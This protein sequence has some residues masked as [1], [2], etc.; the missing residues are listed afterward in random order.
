MGKILN[1]VDTASFLYMCEELFVRKNY[2]FE[3]HRKDPLIIDCGANIGLS[4]IFFKELYPECKIIAFEADS[5]V[6]NT[7]QRNVESFGYKDVILHNRAVWVE[8]TELAFHAEGSWGGSVIRTNDVGVEHNSTVKSVRLL[9]YLFQNIDFL[10]I[11]V[12]GAESNILKDCAESLDKVEHLFFEYHSFSKEPQELHDLLAIL[13]KNG[14]RYHI[15]E[16]SPK[17]SPFIDRWETRR[18]D[19]QLDCFAYRKSV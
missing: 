12:E 18:M 2:E 4:I 5:N 14:F 17:N 19:S 7:L 1:L 16:A 13:H 9:N 6:F 8:D 3:A 11:D 10:K 15:K